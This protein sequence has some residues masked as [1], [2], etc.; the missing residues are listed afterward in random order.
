MNE[1]L[2]FVPARVNSCWKRSILCYHP[3]MANRKSNRVN[4]TVESESQLGLWEQAAS[5]ERRRLPDW[6][7]VTL[8]DA[9][10]KIVNQANHPPQE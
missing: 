7:R 2:P 1:T 4:V 9:A 6:I 5:L 10:R 3:E 8:D